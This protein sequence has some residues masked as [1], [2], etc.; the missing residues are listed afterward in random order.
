MRE[1]TE[2]KREGPRRCTVCGAADIVAVRPGSEP[3]RD[4]F[5]LKRDI[6][7]VAYCRECWTKR[8]RAR[9]GKVTA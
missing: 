5:L 3:I 1:G 6:P 7:D 8:W 2:E 9:T 4:L